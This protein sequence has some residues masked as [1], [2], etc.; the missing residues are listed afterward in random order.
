VKNAHIPHKGSS[1]NAYLTISIGL[2][3]THATKQDSPSHLIKDADIALYEAKKN[4]RNQMKVYKS[5]AANVA[6]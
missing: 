5:H 1:I 6:D 2:S 4:G 3:S